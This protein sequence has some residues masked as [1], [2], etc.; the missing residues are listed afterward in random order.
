MSREFFVFFRIF[1]AILSFEVIRLKFRKN[2]LFFCLGG[3]AYVGLELLYRGRSHISMFAAGGVCFLLLGKL[4]R[5]KPSW[6]LP[7]KGIVGA[8]I[9]TSVELF[10]GLLANR[11][12]SVW[13]YRQMPMNLWGQICLPFSLLWVPLSLVAMYLYRKIEALFAGVRSVKTHLF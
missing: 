10:T 1:L 2:I 7:L 11:D 12:F 8:G 3:G 5:W 9:I 13:D 6:P 4:R